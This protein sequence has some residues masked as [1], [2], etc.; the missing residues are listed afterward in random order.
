[1]ESLSFGSN[2]STH[3]HHVVI[4]S[5][6]EHCVDVWAFWL[7][8]PAHSIIRHPKCCHSDHV[9]PWGPR[10]V[11]IIAFDQ[12]DTTTKQLEREDS[13]IIAV[14]YV[15]VPSHARSRNLALQQVK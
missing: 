10:A 5:V 8:T 1:M 9:T 2:D 14:S 4:A 12:I 7:D 13:I 6:N 11:T 15:L 3:H